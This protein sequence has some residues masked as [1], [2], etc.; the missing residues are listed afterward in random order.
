MHFQETI[1]S[2]R[3]F[4]VDPEPTRED[5]RGFFARHLVP[6][7]VRRPR[8]DGDLGA[9]QRLVQQEEGDVARDALSTGRRTAKPNWF[10]A[11]WGRA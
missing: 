7:R 2:P 8:T 11:R 1:R 3:A 6:G 5:E 10:A 9:V 4:L